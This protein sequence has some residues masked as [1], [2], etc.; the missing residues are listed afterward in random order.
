[1]IRSRAGAAA[2]ALMTA[3][4]NL[5]ACSQNHGSAPEDAG[6]QAVDVQILSLN[7][8]LAQLDP[9]AQAG[10]GG[11]SAQY[12]GLGVLSAYFAQDRAA[13]PNTLLLVSSDSFGASPALSSQF[14]DEPAVKA[15]GLLGANADSLSNHNFDKGIGYLQHLIGLSSYP[16]VAT[17]LNGV[18]AVVSPDVEVPYAV[19]SSG[20]IRIGLLGLTAPNAA[21]KTLPGTFG[22]MTITP[23]I[24]AA[25][26]AAASA[27]MAGAQAV[28]A[29]TDLGITGVATAGAHTGPLIDF[30]RAVVGVD[31]ILGA[32]NA[33]PVAERVGGA[34]VVEHGWKGQ[35]YGRTRL[36][37][38][39][40]TLASTSADIVMADASKVTPDPAAETLLAPYRAQLSAKL[41]AKVSAASAT[42]ALDIAAER[43]QEAPIGDLVTDAMLAKYA[44]A[45]AQIAFISSA[46]IRDSLPSSYAPEDKTL[47]R[48]LPGYVAGP[49]W[50]LVAGDPYTILPFGNSC[51]VRTIS[52]ATLWQVLEQSVSSFPA[53]ANGFLQIAGFSFTFSASA[54]VGARVQS[55]TLGDGTAIGRA[56]TQTM[57]T[58]VDNDYLEGGGDNYGMLI[59]SPPAPAQ[60]LLADVLLEY[61]QQKPSVAP[62]TS[63]TRIIQMP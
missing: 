49:P 9:I 54:G 57:L 58:V 34:L 4:T 42:F 59:E 53:Q 39:G 22:S 18:Q 24:A 45:G 6:P 7:A 62:A 2:A 27:R 19:V 16:Y 30:A 29:L 38:V 32:Y 5:P 55:V 44:P 3:A 8:W 11:G 31:V 35:T 21:D 40:G 61:L 1:M 26:A 25:S 14:S 15:L 56:D 37:F 48:P 43:T 63:A 46:G 36:H 50:D 33:A 23:P 12:G 13:N 52:G 41:D 60:A 17:N 20:S 51:V 28:I 47:R 10:A